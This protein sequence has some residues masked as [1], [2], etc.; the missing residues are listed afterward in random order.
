MLTDNSLISFAM[1]GSKVV[2]DPQP[3]LKAKNS[4][5]WLSD[6]MWSDLQQLQTLKPFSHENTLL[7]MLNN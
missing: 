3:D 4:L 2:S 6:V 7:H 5:A 1:A